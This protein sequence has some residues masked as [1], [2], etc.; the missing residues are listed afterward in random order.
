MAERNVWRTAAFHVVG[1]GAMTTASIHRGEASRGS[2]TRTVRWDVG[3]RFRVGEWAVEPQTGCLQRG[4]LELHLEPKVMA[5]LEYLARRPGQVVDKEELL[6]EIW[7]DTVVSEVSLP[8]T[9]SDLRRALDDDAREPR[10]IETI[11]KRGYRL[12]ADIAPWVP[13]GAEQAIVS[14]PLRRWLVGLV[15][16]AMMGL[17]TAWGLARW[18]PVGSGTDIESLAVLPLRDLAERPGEEYFA[19]AMTDLLIT[20]LAKLDSFKVISSTS[21]MRYKDRR[22]T[23][24]QI[25]EELGVDAVVEGSVLRADEKVR[26]TVQLIDARND[27][28]LWAESYERRFDD[29]LALQSE[30]ATAIARSIRQSL[31]PIRLSRLE[32]RAQVAP[33]A[34]DLYLQGRERFRRR[35]EAPEEANL[36]AAVDLYQK[37]LTIDPNNAPAYAGLSDA[38]MLLADSKARPRDEVVPKARRA[39]LRALRLDPYLAEAHVALAMIRYLFELD[40]YSADLHFRKGLELDPSYALGHQWYGMYLASVGRAD[41]A[42]AEVEVAT[43]LDPFSLQTANNAARV[44]YLTRRFERAAAEHQR[45]AR[46]DPASAKHSTK[47]LSYL[48]LASEQTSAALAEFIEHHGRYCEDDQG[49]PT[50]ASTGSCGAC[51]YSAAYLHAMAGET[52]LAFACLEETIDR[53]LTV[54]VDVRAEPLFDPL[55]SDPRFDELLERLDLAD[56]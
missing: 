12:I 32:Q 19:D 20:D 6:S 23:L 30:V 39:A 27:D 43:R 53:R 56:G 18:S 50:T 24:P 46:I 31:Q 29:I 21:V 8:R 33:D 16:L 3:Q 14:R 26:I 28:H 13:A 42:V 41:E 15:L 49:A 4:D 38:Y 54:I 36:L 35:W 1:K 48:R 45:M 47:D 17:G 25:A 5:V 40:W 37:S 44:Y 52:D 34:Y 9:V 7:P 55:R 2:S 22:R 51:A 11:P 10:F